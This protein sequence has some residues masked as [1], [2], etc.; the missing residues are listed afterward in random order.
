MSN[1]YVGEIRP[2]GLNF[3][4]YGWAF[5]DGSLIAISENETLFTLIG[6]TYGGDGVQ[7]FGLPDLRGRI[8]IH[9]GTL[10]GNTYVI[11]QRAGEEAVTLNVNQIPSHNHTLNALS[12]AGSQPSPSNGVPAS[13]GLDQFS[14]TAPTV[15]TGIPVSNAGGNQPHN[16]IP[17]VLVV[18]YLIALYGIYPSQN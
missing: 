17:P 2:F 15:T 9:Q 5:C 7:T 10:N 6:T 13:S 4:V 11:G 1:Q 12:T 3:A 8:P 16:N 14:T 18:N